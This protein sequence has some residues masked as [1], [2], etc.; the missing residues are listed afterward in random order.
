MGSA[1]TSCA[2]ARILRVV[3]HEV[4]PDRKNAVV[5]R[6]RRKGHT[7]AMAGDGVNDASALAAAE[8]GIAMST[9]AGTARRTARWTSLFSK[10]S[11]QR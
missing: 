9:G 7:V 5:E 2:R 6:L 1:R 11:S 4:L 10:R 3:G 8:V